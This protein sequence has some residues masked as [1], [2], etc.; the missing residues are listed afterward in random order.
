MFSKE[1]LQRP[2][3]RRTLL[4]IGGSALVLASAAGLV[5]CSGESGPD[6]KA[7]QE[8]ATKDPILD[9]EVTDTSAKYWQISRVKRKPDSQYIT[10]EG[11]AINVEPV[12][13]YLQLPGWG[14]KTDIVLADYTLPTGQ[15]V[16]KLFIEKW[17]TWAA[18]NLKG[19]DIVY[20]PYV[21]TPSKSEFEESLF[22]F[23]TFSDPLHE[24]DLVS[25]DLN[26]YITIIP[27]EAVGS[28]IPR[29]DV[30]AR[31]PA[32]RTL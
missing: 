17:K 14:A 9:W 31:R 3:S 18:G 11:Q 27:A 8:A 19:K 26:F 13:Q 16:P 30:M 2:V 24:P 15:R 29:F 6:I 25:R 23:H 4:K 21:L 1:S 5:A 22:R 20:Q 28:P 12:E 10:L 32:P 7:L